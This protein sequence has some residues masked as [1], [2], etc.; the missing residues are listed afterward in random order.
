MIE[1]YPTVNAQIKQNQT[2][3]VFY[4]LPLWKANLGKSLGQNGLEQSSNPMFYPLKTSPYSSPNK[5]HAA[6][7]PGHSPQRTTSLVS[8][9]W[10]TLFLLPS[11]NLLCGPHFAYGHTFYSYFL[12]PLL[13]IVFLFAG[14]H[15]H[16]CSWTAGQGAGVPP[17]APCVKPGDV[18]QE[19]GL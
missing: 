5:W 15:R 14:N 12:L 17:K 7:C 1:Y 13:L 19:R 2:K 4:I 18:Q 9:L 3:T 6:S 8:S 10:Q 11:C 16:L